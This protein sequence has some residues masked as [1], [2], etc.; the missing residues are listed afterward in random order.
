[1]T[2]GLIIFALLPVLGAANPLQEYVQFGEGPCTG[3]T[4][5]RRMSYAS[6]PLTDSE[7]DDLK[8]NCAYLCGNL[9]VGMNR[10]MG[11]DIDATG[12]CRIYDRDWTWSEKETAQNVTGLIM[13][14]TIPDGFAGIHL[15]NVEDDD[16]T[17]AGYT[18]KYT[19]YRRKTACGSAPNCSALGRHACILGKIPQTCDVCLPYYMGAS[20]AGNTLCTRSATKPTLRVSFG[21]GAF[22]KEGKGL[23]RGYNT[24][25]LAA[26]FLLKDAWD[27]KSTNL[28]IPLEEREDFNIEF[29]GFSKN[30]TLAKSREAGGLE[31]IS[32]DAPE[33][34]LR[35][36]VGASSVSE[37][38]ADFEIHEAP[39]NAKVTKPKC[40]MYKMA[41]VPQL[42]AIL[43]VGFQCLFF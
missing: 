11:F 38:Y 24:M 28:P 5:W 8:S 6:A 32:S 36:L 21:S 31:R 10:C 35:A 4:L 40:I 1:M 43:F 18:T 41:D 17:L 25:M 30:L 15:V 26:A 2:G 22:R 19:C 37:A 20:G 39:P 9:G 42:Q 7:Y 3:D 23:D 16:V 27:T 14:F 13:S 33:V 29:Y 34:G 12:S